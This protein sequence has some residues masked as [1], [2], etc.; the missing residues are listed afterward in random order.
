MQERRL[1]NMKAPLPEQMSGEALGLQPGAREDRRLAVSAS[2]ADVAGRA[3]PA[4]AR[5]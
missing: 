2:L 3:T 4:A 1:D 5:A